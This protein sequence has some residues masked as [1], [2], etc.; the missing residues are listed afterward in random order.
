MGLLP[1]VVE[2]APR[3]IGGHCSRSLVFGAGMSLEELILRQAL[4]LAPGPTE[5]EGRASG[6]MMLPIPRAGI[7][8]AV[9][10]QEAALAVPGIEALDLAIHPGE[11]LVPLPD[12]H[13]YLG[14]L[15]AKGATPDAVEGALRRAHACLRFEIG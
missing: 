11:T 10:G 9:A 13:R 4:G 5:R 8:R 2:L 7:L 12:G 1:V 6:V 3:S 14:F 15:F